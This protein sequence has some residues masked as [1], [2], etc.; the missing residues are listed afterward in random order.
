MQ[1][2]ESS[3]SKCYRYN[4][5]TINGNKIL[6]DDKNSAPDKI[7]GGIITEPKPAQAPNVNITISETENTDQIRRCTV[8]NYV[9]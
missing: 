2:R 9:K 8:G 3:I 4:D 6:E 5:F 7:N 1:Y